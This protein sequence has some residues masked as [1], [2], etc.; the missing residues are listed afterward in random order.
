MKLPIRHLAVLSFM[1]LAGAADVCAQSGIYACGHMRRHRDYAI[2]NLRNS[3]YTTAILFNVN[4]EE[5][6]SLTTDYSWSSQTAAEAGGIICRDGAYVF[7]K[8]QPHYV[9]DVQAL[10]T[11]PTSVNRIEICI[12]GWGNGSY[13]NIRKLVE[14]DGTGEETVLYRNFKALKEALPEIVA[15]NND[16][17]QDYN[18]ASAVSFHRMLAEI[19]YK[20]TIA[21]YTNKSYWQNFVRQLN[22]TPGTCE[23]V[24]LQIYGGGAGN[25]PADWKVFGDVPMHVGFDCEASSDIATMQSRFKNWRDTAGAKGGFL[26]NYSSEARNLNEWATAINR[27]FPSKTAHEPVA[28][29]YQD[30]NYGGYAVELPEGTFTQAE[31]ALYG[32][33]AKDIS[34]FKVADGYEVTLCSGENFDSGVKNTWTESVSY[35]GGSWNDRAKSIKIAPVG[36][37]GINGISACGGTEM[38]VEKTSGTDSFLVSG[39]DGR[40][41]EMYN[42]AGIKV[43]EVAAQPAGDTL[44]DMSGM[45]GGVYIFKSGASSVKLIKN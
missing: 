31:M 26:W 30:A 38:K 28:T 21:P 27:I 40:N 5:D 42:A 41:I 2:T 22:S 43:A 11:E 16:Q 25:N 29:F 35:V 39:A 20:T 7:D 33:K 24:Y 12:G 44:I 45:A 6:G 37:S 18:L 10:L 19:G 9:S 4:V 1:L 17:E 14:R 23:L 8:Y 13:G 32:I 3:G 34:S 15:V 36:E